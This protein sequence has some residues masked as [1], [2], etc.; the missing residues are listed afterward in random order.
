MSAN[1]NKPVTPERDTILN[2]PVYIANTT[3][4]NEHS[5][6]VHKRLCD[7]PTFSAGTACAY[8]CRYCYVEGIVLKQQAVQDVLN[9]SKKPFNEVVIRRNNPLKKLAIELTTEKSGSNGENCDAESLLP[10]ELIEKWGLTGDSSISGRFPK[11]MGSKYENKVVFGSPLVDIA[12]NNVLADETVELCEMF[13][14]LTSFQL[15]L[16]SKSPL[17]QSIIAEKLHERLPD[18]KNGAKKRVIFGLS[19]GTLND[20]V[21][22]VIEVHAPSPTARL[23]A[24][25]LLQDNGF[26]TYGMLC[27]ILPQEDPVAYAKEAMEKIRA[28]KC[29]EIWAE[30][31]NLRS[32]SKDKSAN[33]DEQG[34]F[35]A[36]LAALRKAKLTDQANR[37]EKV[38]NDNK[39]WEDYSKKLFN[40]LQAAAESH[41]KGKTKL[42]WLH[43]PRD[44]GDI[45]SWESHTEQGALLLGAVVSNHRCK[46]HLL[47]SC[48]VDTKALLNKLRL[49]SDP[50]LNFVF[51]CFAEKTQATLKEGASK[52]SVRHLQNTAFVDR[53]LNQ[54]QDAVSEFLVSKLSGETQKALKNYQITNTIS[55]PLLKSLVKD[56]NKLIEGELIYNPQRFINVALSE[57]TKTLIDKNLKGEKLARLNRQLLEDAYPSEIV[58]NSKEYSHDDPDVVE[59]L[60]SGLNAFIKSPMK[61]ADDE[62]RKSWYEKLVAL[63]VKPSP[64]AK[65]W[66]EKERGLKDWELVGLN[67]LLLHDAF[68]RE[69]G[70]LASSS[71]NNGSR[72]TLETAEPEVIPPLAELLKQEEIIKHGWTTFLDVGRALMKIRNDRLY[73]AAICNTFEEYCRKHLEYTR[74]TVNRQIWAAQ[75]N[76]YLKPT[77]YQPANERQVRCLNGLQPEQIQEIWKDAKT[78]ASSGNITTSIIRKAASKYKETQPKPSESEKVTEATPIESLIEQAVEA[79]EVNDVPKVLKLL[80]KLRK[81]IAKSD[82]GTDAVTIT[83]AGQIVTDASNIRSN[84]P[85]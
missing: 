38:A 9:E 64:E 70:F 34:S 44:K 25:R 20:E 12:A 54:P 41:S 58:R 45:P 29:E 8:S 67:R 74:S 17:L 51:R 18:E 57:K 3:P 2:K 14:R 47:K 33:K 11:F 53:L 56:I 40:A 77:G 35:N 71:G 10:P 49:A 37:F 62:K 50:T 39:A 73:K 78:I 75:V 21:A 30:P 61:E 1:N 19:T 80:E 66:H 59:A 81:L 4:F 72:N 24:L 82:I 16:L 84:R 52:F 6:F 13:L 65:K 76:E 83:G 5:G 27:P 22:R 31:V 36:T 7:G 60:L 43:Y 28:E 23:E 42:W 79:A 48:D 69:I 46:P 68:P 32:G 63:E 55:Q 26:R 15:R 85:I